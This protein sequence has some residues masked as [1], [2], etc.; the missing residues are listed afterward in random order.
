MLALKNLV[1]SRR[2]TFGF[3]IEMLVY[4]NKIV[5]IRCSMGFS[6]SFCVDRDGRS[7][8]LALD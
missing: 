3:L 4:E 5:E 1:N 6:R 8:G 7:G 2:P